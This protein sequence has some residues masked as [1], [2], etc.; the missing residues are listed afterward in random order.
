MFSFLKFVFKA[1]MNFEGFLL[2][3]VLD[4]AADCVDDAVLLML[5]VKFDCCV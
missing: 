5:L 3:I 4:V 2:S 1:D